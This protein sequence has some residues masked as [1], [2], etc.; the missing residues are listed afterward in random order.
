MCFQPPRIPKH[1]LLNERDYSNPLFQR[2]RQSSPLIRWGL[3]IVAIFATFV[4]VAE[5]TRAATETT[6]EPSSSAAPYDSKAGQLFIRADNGHS[7]PA[8]HLDSKVAF[9]VSGMV[10]HTTFSQTF[11]NP[12]TDQWAEGI[13]VFPM[14][15]KAALSHMEMRIGERRIIG[16]I[17]E[18]FAA[19]KQY[20]K[21]KAAG[22]RVALVEQERPNLFTQNVA[23]IGPGEEVTITLEYQDSVAFD[24]GRFSFR[25][26]MTITPRFMPA[27]S[28]M[29]SGSLLPKH[30]SESGLNEAQIQTAAQMVL[31]NSRP[32]GW[33]APT[34]LVP[35]AHRISPP[36]LDS[37]AQRVTQSHQ[38]QLSVTLDAGLP[39]QNISSPYHDLIIEK[40]QQRHFI[41]TRNVKIPM[42]RDFLLQ[43][44]PVAQQVPSA[45]AFTETLTQAVNH[46]DDQQSQESENYALLM[47]LPPQQKAPQQLARE[48]IYIIDTSGSMG[49]SSIRQAKQSLT[50]ALQRLDHADRFNVVEFNSIHNSLFSSSQTVTAQS[51]QQALRFV[52]GLS[53]GGGTNMAPALDTALSAPATETH[54]R[55]IV[56]ITDGSVGNEAQLFELIHQKL[57]QS[58]LFTV[59]IGSAP[60]SFFMRKSAQFGRGTF[61]HIGDEKEVSEKMSLLFSKLESP[62]LR[63]LSIAW[64]DGIS[65][66]VWPQQ[67]PDLY[68]GEPLLI[69]AKLSNLDHSQTVTIK[70]DLG[71]NTWQQQ[72][73]L[74]SQ[75]STSTNHPGISK[76][77]ARE[78]I[79]ALLDEKTRGKSESDIK[80]QVLS[81][82]LQHQLM[83]PYTSFIAEDKTP[84]RPIKQDITSKLV[85]NLT[86]HGQKTLV[87]PSTATNA[88]VNF[89]LGLIA[90]LLL[91]TQYFYRVRRNVELAP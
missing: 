85:P 76:L 70:G 82:A 86:P 59:A 2:K 54:L 62:V 65:A 60:N 18:K 63:N 37:S 43:W 61:T 17:K 16:Q 21:A 53:A 55:Q 1:R 19:K 80:P 89:T 78:K 72:L 38:I 10:L 30:T 41:S 5:S 51:R 29:L 33:S 32:W 81:I 42:D 39:L 45:A 49:G 71:G 73:T 46:V 27:E 7:Q 69:K 83:S 4:F 12:S 35:D 40:Q 34:A 57:G 26:P 31:D 67:L 50:L 58:R 28:P 64:P 77:W 74:N 88:P 20:Q 44:Q 52:G 22:Q 9:V 14:P 15:E 24:A 23:N 87:Y 36:Q 48:V 68:R 84:A 25:F 6:A 8:L 91:L 90:L 75:H 47:L 79:S 3:L 56:F 66:E 11:R 13:Y